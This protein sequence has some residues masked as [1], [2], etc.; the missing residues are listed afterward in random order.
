M[1]LI[2]RVLDGRTRKRVGQ[3]LGE[4]PRVFK[5]GKGRPTGCVCFVLIQLVDKSLEMHGNMA[6]EFAYIVKVYDTV[7]ATM[8]WLKLYLREQKEE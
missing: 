2:E 4:E 1:K 8:G 7:H 6:L 3:E 5:K